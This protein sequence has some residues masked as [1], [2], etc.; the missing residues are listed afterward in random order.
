MRERYIN[1]DTRQRTHRSGENF[2]LSQAVFLVFALL[3]MSP[4]GNLLA[5]EVE[6][7]KRGIYLQIPDHW[8]SSDRASGVDL[9]AEL[10]QAQ[11][12][13]GLVKADAPVTHITFEDRLDYQGAVRRL[14][15]IGGIKDGHWEYLEIGGWPAVQQE[16]VRDRPKPSGGGVQGSDLIVVLQTVVAVDSTLVRMETWVSPDVGKQE[17]AEVRAVGR[18][19]SANTRGQSADVQR[20]IE[21]LRKGIVPRSTSQPK[22]FPSVSVAP[23][24]P[25]AGAA[26][27]DQVPIAT[28]RG[29]NDG[30][31]VPVSTAGGRD[32]ELEIAVSADGR[33]VIIGSNSTWYYSNDAGQ[34]WSSANLNG[35]DPSVAWGQTGPVNGTFYGANIATP[36]TGMW[37]STDGGATWV[38]AP[39][40][41]TCAQNGDTDCAAAFPDQEHIASDRWNLTAGGDQV[42]SAWRHLNGNWGIVCTQ[43]SAQT[44]STRAYFRAG[45]FPKPAVGPDGFVYVVYRDGN[46]IL[47]DKFAPCEVQ[48]DPMINVP[49]FPV[50]IK[51]DATRVACPTPGLDR[52]NGRNTLSGI[53]IA[54]DDT[55]TNHVYV[56][57]AINTNPGGGGIANCADQNLCS[58]DIVIQ[59]STNGGAIWPA[60]GSTDDNC[61][62]NVCDTTGFA[63]ASD[64]DC[65]SSD[66]V[67]V[68]NNG[69]TARRFMPWLCAIDG[70]AY[71]SWYDRRAAFPGGTTESNNSLTDFYAG[72]ASLDVLGNLQNDGEFQVNELNTEDAQCE[73]GFTTGSTGSW[74][75][76]VNNANDSESCSVQSQLGGRCINTGTCVANVC[77]NNGAA[78]MMNSD[79]NVNQP[80][81]CDFSDCGGVGMND[82]SVTCPCN[83]TFTCNNGR[84]S[85]KYGDYNGNACGAG[86]LYMTWASAEAPLSEP[87][88]GDIDSF[89]SSEIVCCVPQ[90]QVPG[91]LDFGE[92]CGLDEQT[93]TLNVCNTGKENLEITSIT[94]DSQFTVSDPLGGYPVV[95]SP[96]FCFPFEA[97]FSPNG[98]GASSGSLTINNSDPVNPALVVNTTGSIGEPDLNVAI[99]NSGSFGAVCKGDSSDLDITLFNQ[100]QCDLT[101]TDVSSDNALFELP[102]DLQLPLVLS[103]DADFDLPVRFSPEVCSAVE[104]NGTITVSSDSPGEEMLEIDVSGESPC[105]DLVIDP[106][107]LTGLFAFPATVVD[108]E[109]VLGCFSERSTNIRNAGACPL[110]IT[111][112][113]A[114][115]ADF[116]VTEPS[117]FPILLPPGEET[118]GVTVRFTPQ[119]GGD[120]LAPDETN[121]TLTV[122]S[123]DP[124]GDSLAEL[125]GEGVVE[126]GIRFLV[127][128]I[129]TGLPIVVDPV[130]RITVKSKR[131]NRPG[132][133]SYTFTDKA[134][135]GPVSICDNPVSWHVSLE[136][137]PAT[138]KGPGQ[139]SRY[140]VDVKEGNVQDFLSF[141]LDQ[142]EFNEFVV[143][144][145]SGGGEQCLLAPKGAACEFDDEC[146]SGK[147]K[148]PKGGKTCK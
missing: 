93:E 17:L 50:V 9:S 130:E 98:T 34:T 61:V 54:V 66:R 46:D 30:A 39:A 97:N 111:D 31:T 62:A 87:V 36:S 72:S 38:S 108:T 18:S 15:D 138:G 29:L 91:D 3:I 77:S 48:A 4:N 51:Y 86:R 80:A 99:A 118:L 45:D 28:V 82:G 58:E 128:D 24:K 56:T 23:V 55:D 103:H 115:G 40:V 133:I 33:D 117:Q 64:A 104:E 92:G 75:S 132:P 79:C 100:G 68:I 139:S 35:N 81:S 135:E 44:W 76:A 1:P 141:P 110:T 41:Y 122:V 60:A 70:T 14:A 94:G 101:I 6:L 27:P 119:D 89:F 120:P 10:T 74:P 134:V 146:C 96:D 42:Y 43:D 7:D 84:G 2:N 67:A 95:I 116:T 127:T 47:L 19:L 71:V 137:L 142:C 59:D 113:S 140:E 16:Y 125:C 148:G 85:P 144:L 145:Q 69:V 143:E 78:C 88:A 136:T 26:S 83:P 65:Y 112:I 126:S 121:G 90:I 63:C 8:T 12:S 102:E 49:G 53:T 105:P 11:R 124:D 21:N 129:T 5:A 107:A 109:G 147:C 37:T 131:K 20:V 123:D 73:A 22:A 52:C 25:K 106:E 114:A 13:A 57:Y 32:S